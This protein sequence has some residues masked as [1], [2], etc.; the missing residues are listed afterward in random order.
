MNGISL[1]R[2]TTTV[3]AVALICQ[4]TCAENFRIETRIFVGD[5]QE[6]V[7]EAVTLFHDGIVYDFL[8][9]PRQVA[10]FRKP[11]TGRVGRF[12]LLDPE[13][14][15]RTE[16]ESD[17]MAGALDKIRKWAARQSDPVLKFAAEPAFE[18]SFEAETGKLVLA[19][20]EQTYRLETTV[21]DKPAAMDEYREFLDWYARL[22]AMRNRLPP[23]PRLEVNAALAKY[24]VVPV[25][26]ELTQAGQRSTLRAEHEFTWR[27]SREDQ[28]RIEEVRQWMTSYTSV[29]NEEFL[30]QQQT[31][32]EE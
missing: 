11:A 27:L 30:N 19:S 14:K 13:Q 1:G 12:I 8:V 21:P 25:S 29:S 7:S 31:S 32:P 3:L 20:Y 2:I 9:A 4:A 22:N 18:E 23:Q 16:L 15:L 17:R 5:D 26:V 10:V 28:A 6:P 24:G